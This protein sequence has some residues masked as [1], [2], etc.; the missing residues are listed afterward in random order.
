MS[1]LSTNIKFS[2]LL[3]III[4]GSPYWRYSN[5]WLIDAKLW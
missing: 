4:N 2:K 5:S 1:V 3:F